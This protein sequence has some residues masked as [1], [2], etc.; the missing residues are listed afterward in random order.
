MLPVAESSKIPVDLR[1][2]RV[3]HPVHRNR[4][5]CCDA[6]A[7]CVIKAERSILLEPSIVRAVVAFDAYD[8]QRGMGVF[9]IFFQSP[10]FSVGGMTVKK[11]GYA[12]RTCIVPET[13]GLCRECM[14]L[15]DRCMHSAPHLR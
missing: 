12:R 6:T 5:L 15:A 2:Q 9:H 3:D 8:D 10:G 7:S 14:P 13:V 1:F 11:R 4:T